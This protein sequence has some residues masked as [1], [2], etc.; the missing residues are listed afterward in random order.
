MSQQQPDKL[1]REKLQGFQKPMPEDAWTRI[2]VNLNKKNNKK[3][4]LNLAASVSVILV[5][6]YFLLLRSA[7]EIKSL[8]T[9]S[10]QIQP[11]KT[12]PQ[13]KIANVDV[14]PFARVDQKIKS[15]FYK[16]NSSALNQLNAETS[17][18]RNQIES[19]VPAPSAQEMM[20]QKEIVK[21]SLEKNT[22]LI[23]TLDLNQNIIDPAQT[24]ITTTANRSLA[25]ITLVY[26]VE[27]VSKNYLNKNKT[28]EATFVNEKP[29]RFKKLLHKVHDLKNNQDAF[30]ELRQKKDEILAL[31]FKK[32]TEN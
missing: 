16:S 31:N 18:K 27:E 26:T 30:G 28:E 22:G 1:F 19:N 7:P 23:D 29:S 3:L 6:T 24:S 20:A 9:N 8:K 14:I 17:N 11:N 2:E 21:K 10:S 15:K 12:T 4:W 5:S 32:R 13:K 25:S